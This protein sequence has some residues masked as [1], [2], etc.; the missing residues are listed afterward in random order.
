LRRIIV[1]LL[2]IIDYYTSLYYEIIM[3]MK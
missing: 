2:S 3:K 1:L